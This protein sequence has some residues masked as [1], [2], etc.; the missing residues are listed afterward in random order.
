MIRTLSDEEVKE[1]EKELNDFL[2]SLDLTTKDLI[3]R[4]LG[5]KIEQSIC[6]HEWIDPNT[7]KN[8]L[9]KNYLY[10]RYCKVMKLKS[11]DK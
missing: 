6:G 8:E 4:L 11:F 7:Y 5:P 3:K 2:L 1:F 9:D 10:C